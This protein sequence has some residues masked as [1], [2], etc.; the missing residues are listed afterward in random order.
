MLRLRR[1]QSSFGVGSGAGASVC[2]SPVSVSEMKK[3]RQ[4]GEGPSVAPSPHLPALWKCALSSQLWCWSVKLCGEL[5]QSYNI[6]LRG[7]CLVTGPRD[8]GNVWTSM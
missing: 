2:Q 8:S 3:G 5:C 6:M 7:W 4:R 1:F